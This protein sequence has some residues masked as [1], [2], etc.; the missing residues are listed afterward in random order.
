MTTNISRQGLLGEIDA[1]INERLAEREVV[2]AETLTIQVMQC[3]LEHLTI[4]GDDAAW[5]QVRIHDNVRDAV[6]ESL[7]RYR[8]TNDSTVEQLLLPGYRFLQRAYLIERGE[9]P[10]IV[11]TADVPDDELDAKAAMHDRASQGHSEHA[12]E[13]RAYKQQR[14]LARSA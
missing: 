12:A 2:N 6:R 8:D 7:R 4:T 13:L 11:V 1:L 10:V 9:G 14:Q 5:A 3:H